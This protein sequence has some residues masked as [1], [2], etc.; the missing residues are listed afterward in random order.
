[1]NLGVIKNSVKRNVSEIDEIFESLRTLFL[2]E[3]ISKA[4]VVAIL[5]QYL[6]NFDHIE[7]GKN[8]DSEM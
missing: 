4:Q 5:N 6:Y 1:V 7:T 8:L 3:F 2:S